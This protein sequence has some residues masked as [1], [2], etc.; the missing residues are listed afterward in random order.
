MDDP[1]RC[2]GRGEDGRQC[3]CKRVGETYTDGH[4]TLCSNCGHIE[5]A[6]PEAP[7]E[8]G[9][10]I[11]RFQAK[12]KLGNVSLKHL[13]PKATVQ[14]AEA[15]T[16]NGLKKRKPS[17]TDTEPEAPKKK[18]TKPVEKAAQGERVE[19]G[20]IVILVCGT[21]GACGD[22]RLLKTKVPDA[23]QLDRMRKYKL[24]ITSTP[25]KPLAVYTNWSTDEC[26]SYF[27]GIFD[28]AFPYIQSQTYKKD[29]QFSPDVAAQ[30][31]L[32]VIK[33]KQ[34]LSLASDEHPTGSLL[35][36]HCKR[37]GHGA[38]ERVLY[39]ATKVEIPEKR[40]KNWQLGPESDSPEE[41]GSDYDML[42]SDGATPR[43][44]SSKARG[45][46]P[47]RSKSPLVKVENFDASLS[48]MKEAAKR[49]T[50][51]STHS[52][53]RKKFRA[54]ED[55][56][57][58]G[59]VMFEIS[60]SDS[61]SNNFP[62]PS[63]LLATAW[64]PSDSGDAETEPTASA[65]A[66]LPLF[67]P[68][69]SPPG[70]LWEN[71]FPYDPPSPT[72]G[73]ISSTSSAWTSTASLI[74]NDADTNVH[75]PLLSTATAVQALPAPPSQSA[76]TVLPIFGQPG[77]FS[78]I[79]SSSNPTVVAASSSSVA[80]SPAIPTSATVAA[81]SAFTKR[82]AKGRVLSNPWLRK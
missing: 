56:G 5:S 73:N 23:H 46:A 70:D 20:Q 77:F 66:A 44:P 67:T 57:D 62:D 68:L 60:D 28:D 38:A 48:D 16:V 4:R 49:R 12:G 64:K 50:R 1:N 32:A 72:V 55:S 78:A 80:T 26:T 76:S 9:S 18:K 31:W 53:R 10:L 52:I 15:E 47:Q 82:S 65:S 14:E 58:E 25:D 75:H 22:R 29:L 19:V 36:L 27:S 79:A 54:P 39:I 71:D 17:A 69:L 11:R 13:T 7:K 30:K 34:S 21:H 8:A 33:A 37:K 3:I 51:L 63:T 2:S 40:Y 6:H 45:K 74:S 43:K 59:P 35:A 61:D 81:T 42:D 41:D 24:A